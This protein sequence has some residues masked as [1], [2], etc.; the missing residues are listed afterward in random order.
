M[1]DHQGKGGEGV[2]RQSARDSRRGGERAES[3]LTGH[4]T[5]SPP[6]RP[7]PPDDI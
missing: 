2:V 4:G 6:P 3:R 7:I 1:R 5:L